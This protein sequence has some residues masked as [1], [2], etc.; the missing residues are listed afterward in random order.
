MTANSPQKQP[1]WQAIF[2]DPQFWVPLVILAGGL[3]FLFTQQ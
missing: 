2:T 1:F 3:I